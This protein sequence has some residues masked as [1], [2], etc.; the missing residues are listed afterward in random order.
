M[1]SGNSKAKSVKVPSTQLKTLYINLLDASETSLFDHLQTFPDWRNLRLGRRS[2]TV[3][4]FAVWKGN[5][6]LTKQLL[7]AGVDPYSQDSIGETAIDLAR[8]LHDLVMLELLTPIDREG[9]KHTN[10]TLD[11]DI[12]VRS[13]DLLESYLNSTKGGEAPKVRPL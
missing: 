7:E 6:G 13:K 2:W 3:L 5:I 12:R 8:E 10:S 9:D 4:H 1:G 11:A